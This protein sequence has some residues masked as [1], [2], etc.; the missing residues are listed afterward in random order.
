MTRIIKKQ[1]ILLLVGLSML[2]LQSCTTT[3]AG[4]RN[5][6]A[7]PGCKK[8]WNEIAMQNTLGELKTLV[9]ND[10]AILYQRGW[11]LPI[12]GGNKLPD[13]CVPAW[14]ILKKDGQL[15]NVKFLVT[16]NCPVFYRKAWIV[17]PK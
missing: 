13:V 7:V 10:C 3:S 6:F 5:D 17:P 12:T 16:H 11:R 2:V 4:S 8:A 9:K 15:G 1:R 14:N